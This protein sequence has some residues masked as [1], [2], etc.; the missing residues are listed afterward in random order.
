ML[1]FKIRSNLSSRDELAWLMGEFTKCTCWRRFGSSGPSFSM[2]SSS[3]GKSV[4]INIEGLGKGFRLSYQSSLTDPNWRRGALVGVALLFSHRRIT[5]AWMDLHSEIPH[6]LGHEH[7]NAHVHLEGLSKGFHLTCY[8]LLSEWNWTQK[9]MPYG[10][11]APS[12]A[13]RVFP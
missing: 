5:A 11:T 9:V 7:N 10:M 1:I 6:E 4:Y 12:A 3:K 13:A 2:I 8:P